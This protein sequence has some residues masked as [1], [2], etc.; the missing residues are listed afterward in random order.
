LAG[1]SMFIRRVSGIRTLYMIL[2]MTQGG[3]RR[4]LQDERK[5]Q[6]RFTQSS[7]NG[8]LIV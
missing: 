1:L 3:N 8:S 5:L 4:Y 6:G 7:R 2:D